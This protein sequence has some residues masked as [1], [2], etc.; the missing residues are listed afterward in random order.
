MG[1]VGFIGPLPVIWFL[2]NVGRPEQDFAEYCEEDIDIVISPTMKVALIR[3]VGDLLFN[4]TYAP[5]ALKSMP[6][7]AF[8]QTL[9]L[10]LKISTNILVLAKF[11]LMRSLLGTQM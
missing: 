11:F 4:Q 3:S 9:P 10:P 6:L 7:L 2:N 8:N 5:C 1:E